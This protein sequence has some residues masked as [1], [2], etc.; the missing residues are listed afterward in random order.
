MTE[1]D[2]RKAYIRI[3]TNDQT[4]PDE[5]INFMYKVALDRLSQINDDD[6]RQRLQNRNF[7][8]IYGQESTKKN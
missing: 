1:K 8:S 3:R 6:Y 2:I 5:V 4:I 7:G